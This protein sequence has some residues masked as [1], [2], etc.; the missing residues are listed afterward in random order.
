[1]KGSKKSK[2]K[3]QPVVVACSSV[4]VAHDDEEPFQPGDVVM[5]PSG[6][7]AA[8][9]KIV[10]ADAYVIEWHKQFGRGPWIFPVA[11]LVRVS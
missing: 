4:A 9:E 5:L 6:T 2:L 8:I 3:P 10:D 7:L 1:M 11:D